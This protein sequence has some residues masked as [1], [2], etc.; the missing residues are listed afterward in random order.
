MDFVQTF[1]TRIVQLHDSVLIAVRWK[2]ETPAWEIQTVA[3][4]SFHRALRGSLMRSGVLDRKICRSFCRLK[5]VL[6]SVE[7]A[8]NGTSRE[9]LETQRNFGIDWSGEVVTGDV[10]G[11]IVVV[12]RDDASLVVNL[13]ALVALV[14]VGHGAADRGVCQVAVCHRFTDL[15][16]NG[17]PIRTSLSSV[18]VASRQSHRNLI[19]SIGSIP[20]NFRAC[21][22]TERV[23]ATRGVLEK[24]NGGAIRV[25][26]GLF[27]FDHD[28]TR[29]REERTIRG[30]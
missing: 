1:L 27:I 26:R 5:V 15:C 4:R 6:E 17:P 18:N 24:V 12:R 9:I 14:A 11:G 13:L 16:V 29:W 23:P 10:V 21:H 28:W 7:E 8:G 25:P 19:L 3:R 20:V 22:V 30:A 2:L